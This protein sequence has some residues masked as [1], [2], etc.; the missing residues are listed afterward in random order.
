MIFYFNAPSPTEIYTLSLHDAL[1]IC[2]AVY[3]H[4]ATRHLGNPGGAASASP[5]PYPIAFSRS[6]SGA[7][8]S[9]ACRDF[10]RPGSTF[11]GRNRHYSEAG[12]RVAQER[13]VVFSL[14]A[15]VD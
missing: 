7:W 9:R 6:R 1:P 15:G 11:D 5:G 4:H 14:G 12:Q 10:D 2:A 3:A 13:H 8:E